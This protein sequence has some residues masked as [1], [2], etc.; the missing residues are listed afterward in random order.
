MYFIGRI[1]EVSSIFEG[2]FRFR[3]SEELI[4]PTASGASCTV[5]HGVVKRAAARAFVPS[6]SGARSALKES[7]SHR[8]STIS[9][10]S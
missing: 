10:K 5:R 1:H 3:I 9:G 2:S 8:R 7:E 4:S 6:G